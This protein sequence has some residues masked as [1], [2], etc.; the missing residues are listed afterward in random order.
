MRARVYRDEVQ[1]ATNVQLLTAIHPLEPAPRRDGWEYA[2]PIT[3]EDGAWLAG[4]AIVCPGVTVGE[5]TVVGAG[6]VVT[7]SLPP[8]VLAAGA[9]ARAV[10]AL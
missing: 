7:E 6:A 2:L 4:G 10:R 8:D 5:N 9:P 3:I 1:I